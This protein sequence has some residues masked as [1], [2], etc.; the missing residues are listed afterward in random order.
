[1]IGTVVFYQ[2]LKGW[3]FIRPDDETLPDVFLHHSQIEGGTE[4]RKELESGEVVEF[5]LGERNFKPIAVRVRKT[6]G[7]A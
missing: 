7:V 5:Q 2:P 1:M 3:G 4:F 6:D